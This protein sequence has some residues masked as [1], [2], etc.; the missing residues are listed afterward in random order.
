MY[1]ND[2]F[3]FVSISFSVCLGLNLDFQMN[4]CNSKYRC[5]VLV[6]SNVILHIPL[7]NIFLASEFGFIKIAFPITFSFPL[8]SLMVACCFYILS[9]F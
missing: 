2:I 8:T 9:Y 7:V 3:A 6:K 5:E 1:E 4:L